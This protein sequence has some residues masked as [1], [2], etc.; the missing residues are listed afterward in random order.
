MSGVQSDGDTDRAAGDDGGDASAS[1]VS[2]RDVRDA[3]ECGAESVGTP[4]ERGVLQDSSAC[5]RNV[6]ERGAASPGDR[7][8]ESNHGDVS[9][10]SETLE[11][12]RAT[13][14]HAPETR[15]TTGMNMGMNADA[16][17]DVDADADVG[18]D[19][20]SASVAQRHARGVRD[21]ANH[22]AQ[23]EAEMS[24]G[25]TSRRVG[26]ACDRSR[27]REVEAAAISIAQTLDTTTRTTGNRGANAV[28]G[29]EHAIDS[30]S[31]VTAAER[32][33]AC[34]FPVT[35]TRFDILAAL[36]D[37]GNLTPA[38]TAARVDVTKPYARNELGDLREAGLVEAVPPADEHGL[39]RL[40]REGLAA[41][42]CRGEL[43]A[44]VETDTGR[45]STVTTLSNAVDA[46]WLGEVAV[47]LA[48]LTYDAA[49]QHTAPNTHRITHTQHHPRN[50]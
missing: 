28:D 7:V 38:H 4:G 25:V 45:Y 6:K 1:S 10:D 27:E 30:E 36:R 14:Q 15:Q 49:A 22:V 41:V 16:D 32:T 43:E 40:T 13:S 46:D 11:T 33:A 31:V 3:G 19:V 2:H 23:R 47:T 26:E 39:Y 24:A 20:D 8:A 12:A 17:V 29:T 42:T 9:Q 35:D 48:T 37:A 18:V 34:T 21:A 50:G 5:D 44:R